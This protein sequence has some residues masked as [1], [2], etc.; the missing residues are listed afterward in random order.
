M[1]GCFMTHIILHINQQD[2]TRMNI[3]TVEYLMHYITMV[4][5]NLKLPKPL[6]KNPKF[7]YRI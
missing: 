2:F 1:F 3:D 7:S 4:F 6:E 5:K